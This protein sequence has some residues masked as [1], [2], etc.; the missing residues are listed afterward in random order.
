MSGACSSVCMS[1]YNDMRKQTNIR[2]DAATRSADGD[3]DAA[4]FRFRSS[5]NMA[6]CV[7]RAVR[8]PVSPALSTTACCAMLS[9]YYIHRDP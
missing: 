1:E 2:R 5:T 3:A 8:G 7:D 6:S 9:A 4:G